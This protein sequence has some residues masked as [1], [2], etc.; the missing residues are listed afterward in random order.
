[1]SDILTPLMTDF[2]S[3]LA[4]EPRD[5][6]DVMD[7]WRTSCPRLTI[8]EDAVDA[9]LIVQ[10]HAAGHRARVEVTGQGQEFLARH[11]R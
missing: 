8:W 10:V 4:T 11:P 2:L 6:A 5:Y 3:W 7:A 1:M 9:G